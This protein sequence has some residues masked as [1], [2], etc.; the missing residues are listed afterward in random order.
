MARTAPRTGRP[1]EGELDYDYDTGLYAIGTGVQDGEDLQKA[2]TV[3]DV[4]A[5]GEGTVAF[6]GD[7]AFV[8]PQDMP[9]SEEIARTIMD[10]AILQRG[11]NPMAYRQK[12]ATAAVWTSTNPILL[13]GEIGWESDTNK[14]K[15]GTSTT[16]RWNSLPY[17]AEGLTGE[18][19]MD[20]VAAM[21]DPGVNISL[22][23]ND[24][25]NKLVITNTAPGIK[26]GG[27]KPTGADIAK[28]PVWIEI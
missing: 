19:V 3:T 1:A 25:G 11:E 13:K 2:G 16:S 9:T 15:F 26:I 6:R 28:Y 4:L 22:E 18:Q 17:A 7:D 10:L 5:E 27:A 12:S 14:F 21:L 8:V 23:Y 24:A 20:V